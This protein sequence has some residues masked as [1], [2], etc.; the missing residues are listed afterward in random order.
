MKARP[1]AP[2]A[3]VLVLTVLAAVVV[4]CGGGQT[5]AET[6]AAGAPLITVAAGPHAAG[7]AGGARFKGPAGMV[8]D[9]AGNLYVTDTLHD[10]IRE[11]TPAGVVTTLAG[12][13]D[14]PGSADGRGPAARFHYPSAVA[15]DAAGNLYVADTLNNAVR[16]ISP[17]GVVSTLAGQPGTQGSADGRGPAARFAAPS[18]IACDA[19]GNLYVADTLNDTIRK[20]TAGGVVSTLAGAAGLPGSA[21]GRG[22]AARFNQPYGIACD[23]GGNLYVADTAN[24][25]IR[26]ITPEGAVTTLAG[27]AGTPGGADGRGAAATFNGPAGIACDA[28]GNLYVTDALDNTIRKITPAALVTTLV[29]QPSAAA[30]AVGDAAASLDGPWGIARD[31]AGNLYVADHD[32]NTIRKISWMR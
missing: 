16:M 9:A 32:D 8:R 13:A 27:Q 23:A 28:A 18:G 12:A 30:L 24:Y 29:G 10:T 15:C 25:T 26:K 21:D 1:G 2:L 6:T 3:T 14:S 22:A 19:A 20:I 4:A 5:A 31:S 7:R 11:I 17:E